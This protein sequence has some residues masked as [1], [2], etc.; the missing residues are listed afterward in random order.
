VLFAL[1]GQVTQNMLQ[2]LEQLKG[3]RKHVKD[4]AGEL[5][6]TSNEQKQLKITKHNRTLFS[7]A[8]WVQFLL[9]L[10]YWVEDDSAAFEKTDV[11]IEKSVNTVF[12]VFETTPLESVIDLGKFLWK[13]HMA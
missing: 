4:F 10:K 5:I 9:T 6:D 2:R 12:D 3:L 11:V 13:E 7:E 1:N 8:A